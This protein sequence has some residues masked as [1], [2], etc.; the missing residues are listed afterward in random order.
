MVPASVTLREALPT[1]PSGKVDRRSLPAPGGDRPHVEADY[2]APR[3]PIEEQLAKLWEELLRLDRVGVHDDFFE[4]GG[5]S[6]LSIQVTAR[7]QQAGLHLTPMQLFRHPTIA[8]LAALASAAAAPTAEA[9]GDLDAGI[10]L[11]AERMA[12]V[13]RQVGEAGG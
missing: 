13:L 7:A 11:D 1:T 4:L 6:I 5:D 12:A 8:A 3:N 10:E 9:G 2:V